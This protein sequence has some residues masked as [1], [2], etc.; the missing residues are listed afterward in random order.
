MSF[1]SELTIIFFPAT[2]ANLL[3]KTLL[4]TGWSYA[5]GIGTDRLQQLSFL[6]LNDIMGI[7]KRS[8]RLFRM[9]E[10]WSH[11]KD[12]IHGIVLDD[13]FVQQGNI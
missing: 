6:F 3:F 8:G 2:G 4:R 12:Q 7:Q 13:V 1:S 11:Y 10:I 5:G 9:K